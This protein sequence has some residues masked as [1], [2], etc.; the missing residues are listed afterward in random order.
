MVKVLFDHNMPPIIARALNVLVAAEGH[1]AHALRDKFDTKI[2]D[3]SYFK[4]LGEDDDWI[5]ISK[6]VANA[7]RTPERNAIL[8]SGVLAFFLAPSVQKLRINEQAA[9]ILWQWDK[10][11]TQRENLR[12][13]LFLIPINKGSKFESL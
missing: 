13:G 6:D 11:V 10:L 5:V 9:T 7:R 1:E 3:I 12:N 8:K 4:A 2:D